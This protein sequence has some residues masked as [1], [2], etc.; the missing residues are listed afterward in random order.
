MLTCPICEH[1]LQD[2]TADAWQCRC[3]ET[4]PFGYERDD[5][6]NCEACPI[7]DCPRRK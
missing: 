1:E 7:R 5:D 3:G 2:R 4:I 6:E